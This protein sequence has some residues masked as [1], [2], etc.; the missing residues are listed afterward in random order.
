MKQPIKLQREIVTDELID[1]GLPLLQAHY[2]EIAR[3]KETPLEIDREQYLAAERI[4]M[5]RC[6]TAREGGRLI[7]Y[8][9][10][11]IRSHP[12]FKSTIHALSDIL[13]ISPERR[14]IFGSYFLRWCEQ[15]L[16]IEGCNY[17]YQSVTTKYD[18]GQLLERIGYMKIDSTYGKRL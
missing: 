4:G 7:G 1:E 2:D 14:G 11:F 16:R 17:I 9:N 18:F 5:V 8:A 12:H 3:F 15:E 6:F 10:Y 13:Y